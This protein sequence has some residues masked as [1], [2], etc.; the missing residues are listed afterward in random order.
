[1]VI[2]QDLL[3]LNFILRRVSLLF[4]YN[5]MPKQIAKLR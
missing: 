1:M 5:V 4:V 3:L 2:F